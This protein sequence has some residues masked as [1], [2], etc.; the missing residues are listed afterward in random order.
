MESL[1]LFITNINEIFWK[2]IQV[3]VEKMHFGTHIDTKSL[4]I[5]KHVVYN[6]SVAVSSIVLS[7]FLATS[8]DDND[9]ANS[10]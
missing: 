7:K 8:A 3:A 4:E 5:F 10:I 1:A 6:F 2:S 9:A